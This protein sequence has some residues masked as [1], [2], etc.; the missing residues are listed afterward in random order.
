MLLIFT[1]F[2]NANHIFAQDTSN[3]TLKIL[4][5]KEFN[6]GENIGCPP[7]VVSFNSTDNT[8]VLIG[9]SFKIP[10]D[11]LKGDWDGKFWLWEIDQQGNKIRDILLKEAPKEFR[12][13]LIGS[14]GGNPV[15]E[16]LNISK[17]REIYAVG[18]FD[19]SNPSFMKADLEGKNV[20]F[21]LIYEKRD[22]LINKMIPLP[23]NSFLLL[24][25]ERG[26]GLLTKIDS[27]GNILWDRTYNLKDSEIFTDGVAV[28][29]K[30]DFLVAGISLELH[31]GPLT[32]ETSNV[33]ILRC[34]KEGNIITEELFPGVLG[35]GV[36]RIPAV[37]QLDSSNFVV[38]YYDPINTE[39]KIKAFNLNL[40]LLWEKSIFKREPSQSMGSFKIKPIPKGGF[41]IAHCRKNNLVINEY[42]ENGDKVSNLEIKDN[43]W[44]SN[45]G[46]VCT[47]DKAF[48]V[49]QIDSKAS[50]VKII[51]LE[52]KPNK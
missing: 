23:D 6:Y 9:T 35:S 1:V 33:W 17:N 24:G 42:N 27:T 40:K 34:D 44:K 43:I 4:W 2:F 29:D 10:K 32:S 18:Q 48:V 12:S 30:G 7:N 8:L 52:L 21:K 22:I 13:I 28:G 38:F 25:S 16:D 15:F 14:I 11:F 45:L 41:I 5:Q 51:A 20:S 46:L 37:F 26:Q 36:G 47:A 39:F 49:S 31:Q 19:S 3:K 50:A